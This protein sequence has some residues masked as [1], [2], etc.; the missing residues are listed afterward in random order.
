MAIKKLVM[1]W[2]TTKGQDPSAP[3]PI[4]LNPAGE[5]GV[6][7]TRQ[8]K[9]DEVIGGDIDSG[10][11]VYGTF[12]EISGTTNIPMSYE[13]IG[14]ILK[15]MFGAPVTTGTGPYTHTFTSTIDCLPTFLLQE[16]GDDCG[17]GLQ[18]DRYNGMMAKSIQLNVSPDGDYNIAFSYVGMSHRDSIV[19]G[20][21]ELDEANKIV[22]EVT[23]IK[24]AHASLLIDGTTFGVAKDFSLT[25]DRNTVAEAYLG[26]GLNAGDVTAMA[27]KLNGSISTLF[28]T[29][30]YTKAKNETALSA[31]ILFSD[32]TNSLQFTIG[33]M[34]LKFKRESK[35]LGEKYAVNADFEAYKNTGTELVKVVLTN[36]ISEY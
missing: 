22:T 36:N 5:T 30:I 3:K 1:D 18:V 12:N 17:S 8:T 25:Y 7:V 14:F 27:A 20:I 26:N 11:E 19:D 28:D 6:S 15:A 10:S 35:K 24:N 31:D 21:G 32:G 29:N 33:E 34:K 13:R 23:R 16:S 2:E 9:S 4:Y